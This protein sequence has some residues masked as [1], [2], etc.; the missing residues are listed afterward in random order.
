[1]R[2]PMVNGLLLNNFDWL[3]NS[4]LLPESPGWRLHAR[5]SVMDP[6][7]PASSFPMTETPEKRVRLPSLAE[8]GLLNYTSRYRMP[9]VPPLNMPP[10]LAQPNHL[11][12]QIY[13]G[14][15]SVWSFTDG[16]LDALVAATSTEDKEN[17]LPRHV[18]GQPGCGKVF[19]SK[20]RLQRHMVIHTGA[21]PFSCLYP[22]CERTF[23]R[24]D[25]MLQHYRT[26]I[27]TLPAGVRSMKAAQR[28]NDL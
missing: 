14:N 11:Y 19:P 1:M 6:D 3:P 24:R 23:S 10:P 26:H 18:C 28:M 27:C 21:K 5:L 25:N 4:N 8:T 7:Q 13:N 15:S 17:H 20:S 12:C 16:S 9:I 2:I 22:D